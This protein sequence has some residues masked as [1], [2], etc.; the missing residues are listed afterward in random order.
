MKSSVDI[1][2]E[3]LQVIQAE[4]KEFNRRLSALDEKKRK[5]CTIYPTDSGNQIRKKCKQA[6]VWGLHYA[7]V[8]NRY[9]ANNPPEETPS[10]T[11][12]GSD[13]GDSGADAGGGEAGGDA[14]GVAERKGLAGSR[15]TYPMSSGPDDDYQLKD[16]AMSSTERMRKFNKRHPEKVRKYLKKTQDDRVARNR[17]RKKA[18]E[19]YGEKK[20]KNHDVH[21]PNGAQNGNWKLAKK[22]HGRDKNT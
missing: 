17:D 1:L 13:V 21:H 8:W 19:K 9:M 16:E 12:G 18:V 10:T 15:F 3:E 2:F 4:I 20:M 11:D 7:P 6:R 5:R 14:G 22:D